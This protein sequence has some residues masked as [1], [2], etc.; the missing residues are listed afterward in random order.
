M[1]ILA[2]E[3]SPRWKANSSIMLDHFIDGVKSAGTE[4]K[5]VK[6]NEINI[7]PCSGCLRCNLIKRCSQRGDDWEELSRMI[8]DSDVLV[9]SSPVYFFHFPS[10][11]KKVL[12]RF[13][14][15]INV[16]ITENGLIHTPWIEWKKKFVLLLSMGSPDER[17]GD[18]IV[19]SLKFISKE[20][21]NK[22]ELITFSGTRLA[23]SGQIKFGLDKLEK[24]YN[25]LGIPIHFAEEDH[26]RNKKM[27]T[28]IFDF[29]V[30][31]GSQRG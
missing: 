20:M 14:S 17:E 30:E 12:D 15:F 31:T 28:K 18:S 11:L 24:L 2:L 21:G 16:Q 29:G 9:I 3:G 10:D 5:R 19:N 6:V 22:N 27:L 7:Q 1:K 23:I 8:H 13:R 25:K 4:V 26:K